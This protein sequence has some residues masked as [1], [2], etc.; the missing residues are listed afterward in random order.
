MDEESWGKQMM[1][2]P[3]FRRD[4]SFLAVADGE[5]VGYAFCEEYP[6]DWEAAGQSETWVGGLG[7][8]SDWRKRGIA[9]CLLARCMSAMKTAGR[10]AAMIGVDSD[11]P[12]GAQ[13]LYQSLGFTAKTTAVTWQLALD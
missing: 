2:N 5:V 12:S 9:S 1:E 10:D 3:N 7:V 6:E 4:L 11:S 8:L 13:H